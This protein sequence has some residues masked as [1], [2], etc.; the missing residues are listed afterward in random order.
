MEETGFWEKCVEILE[1]SWDRVNSNT[2]IIIL[3]MFALFFLWKK[4][5][6]QVNTYLVY[7]GAILILLMLNPFVEYI[8]VERFALD[9]RIHRFY[10][11]IPFTFVLVFACLELLKKTRAKAGFLLCFVLAV[12]I[13]MG[14]NVYDEEHYVTEN[15]YKVE[16][17][18]IELSQAM[19]E[20]TDA[21]SFKVYFNNVHINYTIRQYDPSFL[22]LAE[23]RTL[24]EYM[25]T[26][27]LESLSTS[28][29]AS[30]LYILSGYFYGH[31][32]IDLSLVQ[33]A[34]NAY[35]IEYLILD[36]QDLALEMQGWVDLETETENYFIYRVVT[37]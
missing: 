32:S 21:E 37:G 23:A 36:Y 7:P 12:W 3:V 33:N 35:G 17:D 2:S 30:N 27:E 22:L 5:E 34:V 11:V 4:R 9:D 25:T 29:D 19:H 26:L 13:I 10:W 16:N 14:R 28:P 8:L 15:I 31:Y 24:D 1:Y 20:V 18:V 6:R